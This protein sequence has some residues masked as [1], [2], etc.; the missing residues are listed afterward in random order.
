MDTTK[1]VALIKAEIDN[2][3][4]GIL[5]F[6]IKLAAA[7]SEENENAINANKVAVEFLGGQYQEALKELAEAKERD[8][9]D[10]SWAVAEAL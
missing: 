1:S 8:A 4:T 6:K 3:T 10:A 5:K 9:E 7:I 2:L